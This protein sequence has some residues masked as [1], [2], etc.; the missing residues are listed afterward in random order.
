MGDDDL[1]DQ[2]VTNGF[3]TTKSLAIAV[4][5]TEYHSMGAPS[6]RKERDISSVDTSNIG[7]I[8]HRG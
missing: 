6:F 2:L 3:Q 8:T 1:G 7:T 4:F 5:I